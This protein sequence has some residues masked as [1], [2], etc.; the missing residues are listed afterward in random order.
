MKLPVGGKEQIVHFK[1]HGARFEGALVPYTQDDEG[2]CKGNDRISECCLAKVWYSVV[3]QIGEGLSPRRTASCN[4]VLEWRN[5]IARSFVRTVTLECEYKISSYRFS[6]TFFVT[7][8][9]S[10]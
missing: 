4:P 7:S 9:R 8:S 2:R 3:L 10:L 6:F 1:R 5:Q